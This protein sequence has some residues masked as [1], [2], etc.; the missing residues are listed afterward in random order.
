MKRSVQKMLVMLTVMTML[1]SSVPFAFAEDNEPTENDVL[2]TDLVIEEEII[3][4]DTDGD[5]DSD[6]DIEADTPADDNEGINDI[7]TDAS[8]EKPANSVNDQPDAPLAPAAPEVPKEADPE[9]VHSAG[10]SWI[11]EKASFDSDGSRKK[12]CTE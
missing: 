6:T 10:D 1:F 11:I 3:D 2:S 9:H 12:V 8:K 7:D 5:T 4:T